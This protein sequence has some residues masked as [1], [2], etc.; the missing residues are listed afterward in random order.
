MFY[1][2]NLSDKNVTF[3]SDDFR[4]YDF[5]HAPHGIQERRGIK[6]R[7]VTEV[8]VQQDD[9]WELASLSYTKLLPP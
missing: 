2:C 9:R 3:G 1:L 4:V 6:E 5:S 8:Y 7:M